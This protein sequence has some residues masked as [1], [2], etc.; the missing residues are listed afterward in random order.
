MKRRATDAKDESCQTDFAKID[1]PV[2]GT[3]VGANR[4]PDQTDQHD[5]CKGS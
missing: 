3:Q 4:N 5:C 1:N 2:F